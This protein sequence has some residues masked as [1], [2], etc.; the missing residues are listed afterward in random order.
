MCA[1]VDSSLDSPVSH[2]SASDNHARI[3]ELL[4]PVFVLRS[5]QSVP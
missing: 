5:L 2:D 4:S 1:A 3:P